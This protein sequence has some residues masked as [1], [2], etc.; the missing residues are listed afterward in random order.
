MQFLV[1]GEI[2]SGK[3]FQRFKSGLLIIAVIYQH[4]FQIQLVS[5]INSFFKG[6]IRSFL[7]FPQNL[8]LLIFSIDL[9]DVF[10]E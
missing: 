3:S 7:F 1:F 10:N 4:P 2:G 6:L 8:E 5:Q 9:P